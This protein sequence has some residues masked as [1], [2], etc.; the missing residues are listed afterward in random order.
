M[1]MEVLWS[2]MSWVVFGRLDADCRSQAKTVQTQGIKNIKYP[3]HRSKPA[4]AASCYEVSSVLVIAML[5]HTCMLLPTLACSRPRVR[6]G[7]GRDAPLGE[8]RD[9]DPD[10]NELG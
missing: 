2:K 6:S 5:R 10:G 4:A 3:P 1:A 8:T 9:W 7:T